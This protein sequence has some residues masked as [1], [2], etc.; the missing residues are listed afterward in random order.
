MTTLQLQLAESYGRHPAFQLGVAA[1]IVEEAAVRTFT[2]A[3]QMVAACGARMSRQRFGR[4]VVDCHAALAAVFSQLDG[5]AANAFEARFFVELG[6]E[7]RRL[8]GEEMSV[9]GRELDR[10]AIRFDVS[11]SLPAALGLC[12]AR[13]FFGHLSASAITRILAI[14]APHLARFRAAA[15]AGKFKR[16]DL[17]LNQG[18]DIRTIVSILN[19]DFERVGV[20][21][22][23]AG[24]SGQRVRVT[25]VALELSVP[26]TRWWDSPFEG[27][28]RP[29]RTLYAHV[30]EA[31]R[32]PKAIVYLTDVTM[33]HGPTSCYPKAFDEL[34]L[35]PLQ[36]IVGRIVGS[37]GNRPDSPL[38][39]YYAKRYHQSMNSENFRRHFMR[40]PSDMRFN[41]HFGWDV[42]PDSEAERNLAA[43]ERYMLGP[44]GTY[45]VFDG[46]R[47]VHRGGM[48]VIGERV[49]LQVI[50]DTTSLLRRVFHRVRG[51]FR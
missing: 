38:H 19:E 39:A 28:P 51:V 30:D 18:D 42:M 3:Y 17:S 29:P 14:G 2:D 47:L 41:S 16:E 44:A 6:A 1:A 22:A 27:L 15:A 36:A 33:E 34:E 25:G 50:F 26:N 48:P 40:L 20:L 45:I 32:N 49:A 21:D 10:R 8:L 24:Y 4:A 13:H 9:H 46:A 7:A 5:Q 12:R 31:I 43:R 11:D 37:V 23:L 35:T